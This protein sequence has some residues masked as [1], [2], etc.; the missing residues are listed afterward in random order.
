MSLKEVIFIADLPFSGKRKEKLLPDSQCVSKCVQVEQVQPLLDP[1]K[2]QEVIKE[3]KWTF[4]QI[5]ASIIKPFSF[6]FLFFQ[7]RHSAKYKATTVTVCIS[8][9]LRPYLLPAQ[10]REP[11]AL[12]IRFD[13]TQCET[14]LKLDHD[15][16]SERRRRPGAA[17]CRR[18]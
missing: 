9:S 6:F 8:P 2:S 4:K 11:S 5:K 13:S 10:R 12:C 16:F 7:T 17:E 15:L 1:S 14:K 3:P 18:R